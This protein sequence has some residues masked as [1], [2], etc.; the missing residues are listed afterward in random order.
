ML[1][2]LRHNRPAPS[3]APLSKFM[4]AISVRRP[5][6]LLRLKV[7]RS[8]LFTVWCGKPGQRA[9]Y[10]PVSFSYRTL[11]RARAV[12]HFL[13]LWRE[14]NPRVARRVWGVWAQQKSRPGSIA[15]RLFSAAAGSEARFRRAVAVT[16]DGA[17]RFGTHQKISPAEAGPK[18]RRPGHSGNRRRKS[19]TAALNS[20]PRTRG[21]ELPCGPLF[22]IAVRRR[23]C[24]AGKP[25]KRKHSPQFASH[26]WIRDGG[27]R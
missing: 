27:D 10:G 12:T 15:G 4:S 11:I 9:F 13:H 21:D 26:P 8:Y 24:L 7:L 5:M 17:K 3:R 1:Q 20:V 22:A 2:Q 25:E 6:A 18:S 16:R 23:A 14:K 19:K